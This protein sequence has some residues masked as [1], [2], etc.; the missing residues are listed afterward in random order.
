M[1]VLTIEPNGNYFEY[2]AQEVRRIEDVA[3]QYSKKQ[4]PHFIQRVAIWML[5]RML[6][7]MSLTDSGSSELLHF[8]CHVHAVKE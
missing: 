1:E 3:T 4:H 8:G 2:I 5:L 6:N 7:K